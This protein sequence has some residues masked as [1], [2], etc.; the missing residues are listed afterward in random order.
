MG[1][2]LEAATYPGRAQRPDPPAD[3]EVF[4]AARTYGPRDEG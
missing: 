3:T 1:T 4:T 2:C